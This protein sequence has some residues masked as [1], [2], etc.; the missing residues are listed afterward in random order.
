MPIIVILIFFML[1][2]CSSRSGGHINVGS[3]S[4][5]NQIIIHLPVVNTDDNSDVSVTVW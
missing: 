5:Q 2:K 4:I 1:R 3:G